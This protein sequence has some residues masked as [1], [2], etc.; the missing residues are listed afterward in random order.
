MKLDS[1]IVDQLLVESSTPDLIKLDYRTVQ[2]RVCDILGFG[3]SKNAKKVTLEHLI[4]YEKEQEHEAQFTFIDNRIYDQVN[5][6]KPRESGASF[7]VALIDHDYGDLVP[8]RSGIIKDMA[9]DPN[10]N[11]QLYHLVT[12]M[13]T[14]VTEK[15][16]IEAVDFIK[17]QLD[18]PV[19]FVSKT[20][21][22]EDYSGMDGPSASLATA[23]AICSALGDV[24]VYTTN[25][26]TGTL[27][28]SDGSVGP[29]GGIYNKAKTV[30]RANQ[31]LNGSKGDR[32]MRF[33][34]PIN[35][36]RELK[37]NLRIST[38]PIQEEIDLFPV[39]NFSEAFYL[40][41]TEEK[42]VDIKKLPR[43]AQEHWDKA[44]AKIN[45]NVKKLNREVLSAYK[46]R[47]GKK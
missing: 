1:E 5:R 33:M 16:F 39:N 25:V 15:G 22:H 44:L 2:K 30:W 8:I 10:T 38:Y 12:K 14:P 40:G 42:E 26:Y 21:F 11:F 32:R 47:P 46:Y 19:R 6:M 23:I 20:T 27:N 31:K 43:L 9:I 28:F 37:E 4:M 13:A 18:Y 35:N 3:I 7:G 45:K 29:I 24:P 36:L 17:R 41:T 34:F